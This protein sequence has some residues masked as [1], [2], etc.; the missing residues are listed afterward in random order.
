MPEEADVP[1]EFLGLI[2]GGLIV[3]DWRCALE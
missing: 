3:T 1:E 2:E